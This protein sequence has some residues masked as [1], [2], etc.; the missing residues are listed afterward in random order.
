MK[1]LSRIR[2]VVALRW[3]DVGELVNGGKTVWWRGPG[4]VP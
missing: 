1:L 4:E 3:N 2:E